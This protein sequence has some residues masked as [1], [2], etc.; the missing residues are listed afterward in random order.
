MFEILGLAGSGKSS[1][2]KYIKDSKYTFKDNI[3]YK[4]IDYS[5]MYKIFKLIQIFLITKNIRHIKEFITFLMLFK[6][7]KLNNKK[8]KTVICF[9][10]GPLFILTKLI[11]EIPEQEEYF[12]DELRKVIPY[13]NEIIYLKTPLEVLSFRINNREQEH[14]I[15]DKPIEEQSL[16]LKTYINL[17]NKVINICLE[18]NVNVIKINTDKHSIDEVGELVLERFRQK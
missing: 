5:I 11:I 6:S 7:I 9:D 4:K 3:E 2:I 17:Y 12:L 14:R 13:Y 8:E 18:Q 10:Q 1:T 16:F 15:K